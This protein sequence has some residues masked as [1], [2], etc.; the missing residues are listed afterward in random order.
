VIDAM[1]LVQILGYLPLAIEQA[2]SYIRTK[3]V[4]VS[5][6]I[7]LYRLNQ[8]DALKEALPMS[9]KVYYEHTVA[10]TW[11]IS[12]EEVDSRDILA[13]E[14]LRLIAFLNGAKIQKELF[15]VGGKSLT[16]EWSFIQS[17]DMDDR[18][19]VWMP[20]IVLFSEPT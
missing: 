12:F 18:S 13:S 8:S 5:R 17:D 2:G 6:Y 19:R 15:E 16:E 10:T 20:A 14:L 7:G 9:H 11:K 4:S 3:G 1:T